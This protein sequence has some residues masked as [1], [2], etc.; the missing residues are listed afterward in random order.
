MCTLVFVAGVANE[1]LI[2]WSPFFVVAVVVDVA[3]VFVLLSYLL[4]L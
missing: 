3:V 1:C 4:L 2:V